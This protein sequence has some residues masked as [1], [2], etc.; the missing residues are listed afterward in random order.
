MPANVQ[1][2]LHAAARA[3][4]GGLTDPDK[5]QLRFNEI[6]AV[7]LEYYPHDAE[8]GVRE[9]VR[10]CDRAASDLYVK[11]APMWETLRKQ[12]GWMRDA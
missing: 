7:A 2:K 3:E 9:L 5:K 12:Y 10:A 1:E 6:V 4:A 8:G 11:G